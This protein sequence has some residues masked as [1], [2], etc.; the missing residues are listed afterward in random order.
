M[1]NR[2]ILLSV[3]I[4]A[5]LLFGSSVKKS[6]L[7]TGSAD[8]V[9]KNTYGNTCWY[10]VVD[11]NRML[12]VF[13]KYGYNPF[14]HFND[15]VS[16]IKIPSLEKINIEVPV[17]KFL[18]DNKNLMVDGLLYEN[19]NNKKR[20][21]YRISNCF[22]YDSENM[23]AGLELINNVY[24]GRTKFNRKYYLHWDLKSNKI[25]KAYLLY[26]E[27][28]NPID[29]KGSNTYYFFDGLGYN[30]K[31]RMFYGKLSKT[32]LISENYIEDGKKR[33]KSIQD[34]DQRNQ[35]ISIDLN[36]KKIV[37]EIII[38]RG[39]DIFYNMDLN[40]CFFH[41]YKSTDIDKEPKDP[42]GFIINF[43]NDGYNVID[44]Q[45]WTYWAEFDREK[46]L[47]YQISSITGKM[48]IND[49][50]TGK[51][52][53]ELYLGDAGDGEYRDFGLIEPNVLFYN[54][55]GR[56]VFVDCDQL[57]IIKNLMINEIIPGI[58]CFSRTFLLPDRSG[59]IIEERTDKNRTT[60]ILYFL[61]YQ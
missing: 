32:V 55:R 18:K 43:E 33:T 54:I 60:G 59:M 37:S 19:V 12:Y 11:R 28:W 30:Y 13:D 29:K 52:I 58:S 47:L 17:E 42:I 44:S 34:G 38:N 15:T 40:I 1:K 61:K 10:N 3:L 56:F 50:V 25:I 46:N 2:K 48:W 39:G 41:A 7:L 14:E 9:K 35:F 49:I 5:V 51:K 24:R 23:A 16:F 20:K 31:N 22:F 57:K 21:N 26:D 6:F 8:L 53:N 36:D 4:F 45:M 27:I